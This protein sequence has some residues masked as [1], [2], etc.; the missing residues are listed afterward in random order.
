MTHGTPEAYLFL[1]CRCETCQDAHELAS[2][3]VPIE[4]EVRVM[5]DDKHGTLSGYRFWGCRCEWCTLASH[6]H[7]QNIKASGIL[8][9]R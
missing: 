4:R 8:K 5:P 7:H 1:G 3:D 9:R 6:Q 2:T